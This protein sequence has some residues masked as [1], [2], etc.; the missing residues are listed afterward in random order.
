M[1]RLFFMF[2]AISAAVIGV[3][4]L[5]GATMRPGQRDFLRAS[6]VVSGQVVRLNAGGYYPR[7]EFVTKAGE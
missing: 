4:L 5:I 2:K 1:D 6:I 3:G 7:I